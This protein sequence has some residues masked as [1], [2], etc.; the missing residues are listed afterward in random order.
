MSLINVPASQRSEIAL[1]DSRTALT[2]SEVD[3]RL[4]RAVSRLRSLGIGT[5][6]RVAVFAENSVEAVLAHLAGLLAGAATVPIN[7]HLKPPE[8][9]HILRDSDAKVLLVGPETADVGRQTSHDQPGIE[10]LGWRI[11]PAQ[12]VSDWLSAE[13]D[14]ESVEASRFVRPWP[15]ILYTSGTTGTPKA[16][17]LPPTMFAGG[18]TI[19]EHLELLRTQATMASGSS[20]VPGAHLVVGPLYH[21]GPLC[22]YRLLAGGTPVVVLGRFD[23]ERTLAAIQEHAIAST[24]MVPTH[25]RRLLELPE[26]V[27]TRYDVSTVQHVWTTGAACPWPVKEAMIA[28]WGPV[29]SE[30]YGAT[31]VGSVT[32][33]SAAEWIEHKGSVGR[34]IAPF[35]PVVVDEG[36]RPC[37]T[38]EIGR[39]FFRD[40]TGRGVVYV[41][42]PEKSR[43]AH[44]SPGVFTLGEIGY[45]DD[46]GYVYITD[47]VSDMVISGGVNIYPAE[48]EQVLAKHPDVR[49]IAV[50]GVPDSDMGEALKALVVVTIGARTSEVE[51][52]AHCREHLAHY[53]CPTTVTFVDSLHRTEVGKLDKRALRAPYWPT[54]RTIG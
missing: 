39:L 34:C 3:D 2:W 45:V 6:E 32:S 30:A 37:A 10:L 23:P 25:F 53:K 24:S 21:T 17:E 1:R 36:G 48:A 18:S 52:L 12:G 41:H 44:L 4:D 27:R 51:L 8:V 49:D 46:D 42:D 9:A 11:D 14:A 7:F 26:V 15:N 29:V 22:A 16:T 31:E 19:E 13:I 28:W 47:R 20:S 5:G 38:G 40:S 33:I 54:E 35:E 43:A 50:I